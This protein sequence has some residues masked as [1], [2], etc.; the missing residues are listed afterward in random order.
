[1]Y[2]AETAAFEQDVAGLEDLATEELRRKAEDQMRMWRLYQFGL[3]DDVG[4]RYF[5]QGSSRGGGDNE[6]TGEARFQPAAPSDASALVL[7]WLD[8]EV[9]ITL[10]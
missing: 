1:V 10:S 2:P 7:S 4:T 8:L 6:M 9:R 5:P 3:A